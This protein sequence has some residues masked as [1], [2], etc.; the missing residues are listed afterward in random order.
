MRLECSLWRHVGQTFL[1]YLVRIRGHPP[2]L[3]V[4]LHVTRTNALP[5]GVDITSD[6]DGQGETEASLFQ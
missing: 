3:C 5:V 4:L 1:L 6:T 2:R